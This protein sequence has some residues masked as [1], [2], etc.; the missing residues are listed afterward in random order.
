MSAIEKETE[1]ITSAWKILTGK[2]AKQL[3][4]E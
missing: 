2:G 3:S 1:P 4:H